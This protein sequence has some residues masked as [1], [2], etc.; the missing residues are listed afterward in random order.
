MSNK[1]EPTTGTYFAATGFYLIVVVAAYWFL[2]DAYSHHTRRW[3]FGVMCAVLAGQIV[4]QM[5]KNFV[6]AFVQEWKK[7]K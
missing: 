4:F 1:E 7:Q 5:A 2:S 6:K 3:D